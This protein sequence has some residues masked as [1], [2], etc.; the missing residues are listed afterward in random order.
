[1]G[2]EDKDYDAAQ[3]NL[4]RIDKHNRF[5]KRLTTIGVIAALLIILG[6]CWLFGKKSKKKMLWRGTRLNFKTCVQIL[7]KKFS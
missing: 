6:V 7:R 1:M 5:I 2:H 3:E 4:A